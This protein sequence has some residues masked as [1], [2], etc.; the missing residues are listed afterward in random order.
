M[1]Q[2]PLKLRLRNRDMNLTSQMLVYDSGK[3]PKGVHG[4]GEPN[5]IIALQIAVVNLA[6]NAGQVTK[7]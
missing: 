7:Q 1:Q 5:S 6:Q 3:G 2:L 4:L